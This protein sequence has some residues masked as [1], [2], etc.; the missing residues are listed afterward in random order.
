VEGLRLRVEAMKFI[1]KQMCGWELMG[2]RALKI[3][4]V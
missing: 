3:S 1:G 2:G 4:Q